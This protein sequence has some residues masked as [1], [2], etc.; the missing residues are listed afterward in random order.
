[1]SRIK[2]E[3]FDFSVRESWAGSELIKWN[4]V[5]ILG[6]SQPCLLPGRPRKRSKRHP[7]PRFCK[8]TTALVHKAP[9]R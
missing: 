7:S 6:L 3:P 1:M 2:N 8:L 5:T 9:K 4:R